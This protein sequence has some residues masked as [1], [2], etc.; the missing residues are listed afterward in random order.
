MTAPAPVDTVRFVEVDAFPPP[1]DIEPGQLFSL[2]LSG[3]TTAFTHGLHRFAAKFIPQVP[4]WALDSFAAPGGVVVDPFMGSGTTLVEALVRGGTTV[5]VDIDPLAR[6][7]ARAKVT[8]VDHERIG[9]LAAELAAR[10]RAPAATLRPP[11]PDIDNFDR[12]FSPG[13]WGRVQSLRDTILRLDCRDDE[14]AFLLVVFSSTLRWVSNADDQSQKTYVS[15]TLRKQPPP[16][17]DVFW[18]FLRRAADGLADLNRQRRGD[19]VAVI[20]DGADATRL[21]LAPASVDLAVAS[22]PYLDSVD[23]PYNMM[24]EYFW[25][26]SLLGVPDRRSFNALRRR[27]IGA[28]HP[29][30]TAG[31]PPAL[32]GCVS[33][34]VMPPAR[35]T[36]ATTYFALM[37]QHFIEMARCLKPGARYVFVVGNSQTLIDM[38]PLHDAL[39]R[40]AAGA[41][42]SLERAFGYRI[43][44]HYMKFP[45][46]GRGGIILIDWV[47]VFRKERAVT[48][49]APLPL[50]WLTLAPGA[51]AH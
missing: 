44:R 32:E 38:V 20:P 33:L 37:E 46:R 25:L 50:H 49:P 26:G 29:A 39:V 24:L 28:K 13:Q 23:Y 10:W 17:A 21:G 34:E 48:P 31:L 9:V 18:R 43:R 1:A 14:R 12:W 8:A 4:A 5:G 41:G 15:G 51:V 16:V 3:T 19:A 22:P 6:F 36:A 27:P 35:R 42:L 11:M 47:L 30:V 45:R 2:S 7:I 40:L